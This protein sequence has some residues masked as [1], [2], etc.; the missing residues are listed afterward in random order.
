MMTTVAPTSKHEAAE[1]KMAALKND[2]ARLSNDIQE[3]NGNRP[4]TVN[5][6]ELERNLAL[7]HVERQLIETEMGGMREGLV[8]MRNA[9][10]ARAR[11]YEKAGRSCRH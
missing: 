11:N 4:R 8:E 1:K 3:L 2:M 6:T 10:A 5:V 9:H 7:K